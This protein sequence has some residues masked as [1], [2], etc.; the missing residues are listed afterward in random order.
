M[1]DPNTDLAALAQKGDAAAK[2]ALVKNNTKF[3]ISIARQYLNQGVELNDLVQEGYIGL[4]KSIDKFNTKAGTKFLTYSSW[5][6]KQAILQSLSENNRHVRLPANRINLLEQFRK[7]KSRLSQ[8]LQ[9]EASEDEVLN[10]LD[11]DASQIY[12]QYSISY[13]TPIA[14]DEKGMILDVLENTN[15]PSPDH[16]LL[17][18][19]FKQELKIV[20][21][22][23]DPRE[24]KIIQMLFGIN[25]ERSYTL[26]E[27]GDA[28]DLTRERV[29]QI[30]VKALKTLKRLNFR[31]RLNNLKD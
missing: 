17:I 13:H 9:R 5:W 28:L 7:K 1:N 20:L 27:V 10:S 6:I 29:R 14:D 18:E 31:R 2:A 21:N 19:A 23:L 11:L 16:N 25:Y 30:K 8:S 22:K 3:V 24:R 4:L 26:E 12:N 15:T